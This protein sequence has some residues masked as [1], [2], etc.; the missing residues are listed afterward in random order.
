MSPDNS[1]QRWTDRSGLRHDQYRTDANLTARQSIYAYQRPRLDL[2][3]QVLG[4]VA[5][6][7][8]E[9]VVDIGCGNGAYLAEL[10][11]RGHAGPVLGVDFS[12]GMLRAARSR[13]AR[14][15]LAAGDAAAPP[16]RDG[17]ADLTLAMHML[18]HVPD[19]ATAVRELR[20][21]TRAGG[22]VVVVLNGED[23]LRE[24]RDLTAAAVTEVTG[25]TIAQA[26]RL[27]L[28]G[29]AELLTREFATVIR[30][31]FAGELLVPAPGP[32]EDYVRSTTTAQNLADPD[33][34]AS[35]V[36][37]LIP[38]SPFRIRTHSGCLIC[39]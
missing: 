39:A 14:A 23:H 37:R 16:L 3:R 29:G 6:R 18:Y 22:Q 27:D 15:A 21:I 1:S 7:G 11:R 34:L 31:D 38:G 24:M 33:V 32:V 4:L 12:P 36:T 2:A 9:T 20:R 28:D 8:D 5:P 19:P 17:A 30:H 26:E 10:G 25:E 35:A 13:S